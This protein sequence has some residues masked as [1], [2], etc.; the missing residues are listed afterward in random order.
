MRHSMRDLNLKNKSAPS[1]MKLRSMLLKMIRLAMMTIK[2][3]MVV[4]LIKMQIQKKRIKH[5]SLKVEKCKIVPT[6]TKEP[7]MQVLLWW[8]GPSNLWLLLCYL[9]TFSNKNQLLLASF[10][11]KITMLD[12]FVLWCFICNFKMRSSKAL[13]SWN[14]QT[15][16]Q[17]GS[18]SGTFHLFL[19]HFKLKWSQLLN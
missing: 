1:E 12:L 19:V 10:L 4:M 15:I 13:K 8:F 5:Q 2:M 17:P 9:V 14:I 3:S 18:L 7:R 16:I 11:S 6:S